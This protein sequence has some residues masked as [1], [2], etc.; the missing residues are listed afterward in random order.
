MALK[1]SD[2]ATVL[3]DPGTGEV[4]IELEPGE[5]ALEMDTGHHDLKELAEAHGYRLGASETRE[6][7]LG[8]VFH[9]TPEDK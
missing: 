9:P 1:A 2:I 7:R 4:F 6:G 5:E 8:R 3:Q